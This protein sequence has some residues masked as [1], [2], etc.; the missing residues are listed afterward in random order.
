[1]A[2][3][4]KVLYEFEGF[5]LNPSDHSLRFG[6]RTVSL[7]PKSFEILLAL[8][9][10][11]GHLVTKEELMR[12]IW[13][14][15]FV[16]EAN[17]T[18]NVSALRKALGD[19][20]DHQQYIETVPKLGYRFIA[21]VTELRNGDSAIPSAT[22]H[23]STEQQPAQAAPTITS[24]PIAHVP[25]SSRGATWFRRGALA[26]V[27][28]ILVVGALRYWSDR[29]PPS[30]RV[31]PVSRRLAILPFQNVQQDASTDFLGYSLADAVITKL[32]Y[33]QTLR[34]RPSYAIEKYRDRVVEIPKVAADLDVDTLLTGNFIRDGN[35]LRITCQLID[36]GTRNILWKGSFDI[37]NQKLL[38]VQDQ[39]TEQIIHGLELNL[40]S[41]EAARLKLDEPAD[42]LAYEY[43]L[44]GVDLYARSDFPLAIRML[45]KS[46]EIDPHYALTWAY[47]GRSYNASASFQLEG[48][49][50]YRKA[51]AAFDRALALQP[52]QIETRVYIA[53]F[54]TDTGKVEQAVPLLRESLKANPHHAE[55]HW[56]LGYAYRFAGMLKESIAECEQARGLDPGVKI[57]SSALN[58]YLYL[59][60]YDKFLE[61][62]P[63]LSELPFHLFYRGFAEYH[64][65]RFDQAVAD[66]DR[67]FALSPALLQAQVGKALSDSIGQK[68]AEGLEIIH[69]AE[70]K[71]QARGVGD[72]EAIYKL[73]QA[74][75]VLGDRTSALRVLKHSIDNGFFP[76]PYFM[77]DPLLDTLRGEPQFAAIM[78][79]ARERHEAFRKA[80]F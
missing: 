38:T 31:A 13:P 26:L 6:G 14:D 12:R 43:Y 42:P 51:Q 4:N 41:S 80:F 72:S 34:V 67:S 65:K 39:V 74:Y 35:D 73:A 47:L 40:S 16:E 5:R 78:Q 63:R 29:R 8:I 76:Y 45:E 68:Q 60:E 22:T 10:R 69:T 54:F 70:N 30:A 2:L 49:E 66:F 56:E 59:G 27:T 25:A 57:N 64:Q 20:A 61:D 71:I 15:S 18:V 37:Q 9:E 28:S 21:P 77:T 24:A 53:N 7:T 79:T 11:N 36:V 58:A 52:D 50:Y 46:S 1:M 62:L 48:R 19:T 32:G 75:A 3:G 17:L 33:V 55:L 23:P 44:R